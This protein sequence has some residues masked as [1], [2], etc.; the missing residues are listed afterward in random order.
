MQS[1]TTEQ[2]QQHLPDV[3]L[4]VRQGETLVILDRGEVIA[5]LGP[6][7]R[8]KRPVSDRLGL[9]EGEAKISDNWKELSREEIEADFRGTE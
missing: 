9:L 3:L 6:V 8:P 2:I 7:A 4:R 1:A 5:P